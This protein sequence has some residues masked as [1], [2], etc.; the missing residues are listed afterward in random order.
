MTS[1]RH[2][3]PIR[4][5]TA[6]LPVALAVLLVLTAFLSL[7]GAAWAQEARYAFPYFGPDL[8]VQELIR[9]SFVAQSTLMGSFS[10]ASFSAFQTIAT[11]AALVGGIFIAFNRKLWSPLT[12]ASWLV[13]VV[14]IIFVPTSSR[15]LFYPIQL[16]SASLVGFNVSQPQNP[17]GSNGYFAFAPQV[18]AVDIASRAQIIVSDMFRSTG[19]RDLIG[20]S[21]AQNRLRANPILNA[22]EPWLREVTA[23]NVE[24][25]CSANL[26]DLFS[27]DSREASSESSGA[28]IQ[29]APIIPTV[30]FSQRWNQ[31]LNHYLS[32]S[33]FESMPP[34][35]VF[36]D[37]N[38]LPT[39]YDKAAYARGIQRIYREVTGQTSSTVVVNGSGPG[40]IT[41]EQALNAL[42]NNFFKPDGFSRTSSVNPGFFIIRNRE[43]SGNNSSGPASTLRD[44]YYPLNSQTNNL[45]NSNCSGVR[46]NQSLVDDVNNSRAPSGHASVFLRAH[47]EI[48]P[49]PAD[50]LASQFYISNPSLLNVNPLSTVWR[51]FV[52]ALRSPEVQQMPV[53]FRSF[54]GTTNTASNGAV[55]S[56]QISAATDTGYN[57]ATRGRELVDNALNNTLHNRTSGALA[58][59]INILKNPEAFPNSGLLNIGNIRT[60]I[61]VS[62]DVSRT[63]FDL[64]NSI[65]SNLRDLEISSAR[66]NSGARITARER[67]LVALSD[68]MQH[69]QVNTGKLAQTQTSTERS[70]EEDGR[71][72]NIVGWSGLTSV[73]G[74]IAQFMGEVLIT[75][76]AIF[77]GPIAQAFI[78]FIS[79][80]VQLSLLALIVLTPFL[81][82]AG[83]LMPG[84]AAGIFI[85]SVVAAFILQF[86]PVTLIIL[87]YLGGF[88]YDIIGATAGP[89]AWTMQNMLIIGMAGLYTSIVSLTLYLMFKLGDPAAMLGRLGA[90]DSAA[91]QAADAGMKATIAAGTLLAG[92]L[93]GAGAALAGSGKLGAL[94]KAAGQRLGG[95]AATDAGAA[96]AGAVTGSSSGTPSAMPQKPLSE[97]EG[98]VPGASPAA[99]TGNDL[100]DMLRQGGFELNGPNGAAI[101]EAAQNNPDGKSVPLNLIDQNGTSRRVLADFSGGKMQA[102][103]EKNADGTETRIPPGPVTSGSPD[104]AAD[105]GEEQPAE[106]IQPPPEDTSTSATAV[107]SG[108]LKVP[109]APAPGGAAPGSAAPAAPAAPAAAAAAAASAQAKT[110]AEVNEQI[111]QGAAMTQGQVETYQQMVSVRRG[112]L[113]QDLLT[114]KTDTDKK[115]IQKHIDELES[116]D[117][118]KA[119]MGDALS[120]LSKFDSEVLKMN[121]VRAGADI[122]P[123]MWKVMG[124]GFLG[125]FKAVGGG[126]GS[127]PVIG[128]ILKG[129]LNEYYEA[130]ERA[131]AWQAAGGY[132]KY[133]Q[134]AADAQRM[135][136]YQQGISPLAA[137]Y[138]YQQMELVGGFQ[139]MPETARFQ[140]A[141]SVARMRSDY[142]ALMSKTFGEGKFTLNDLKAGTASVNINALDLQG[143]GRVS[144]ASNIGS[145]WGEA[146]AMQGNSWKV[147]VWDDAKKEFVKQSIKPNV[148]ALARIYS[149]LGVKQAGKYFDE[150]MTN[151]YGIVEKQYERGSADWNATRNMSNDKA[152]AAKFIGED[153]ST[154]Y[155]VAGHLK[156]VQG[157][158]SFFGYRGSYESFLQLRN[159]EEG[160]KYEKIIESPQKIIDYMNDNK[161]KLKLSDAD[162]Q[163]AQIS[164]K[165]VSLSNPGALKN[166]TPQVYGAISKAAGEMIGKTSLPLSAIFEESFT[167]SRANIIEK[168]LKAPSIINSENE[169]LAVLVAKSAKTTAEAVLGAIPQ[170]ATKSIRLSDPKS[171]VS[172]GTESALEELGYFMQGVMKDSATA[173]QVIQKAFNNM[174]KANLSNAD[175]A[176]LFDV[177]QENKNGILN[178]GLRMN[179]TMQKYLEDAAKDIN[180][181]AYQNL[182]NG[183]DS[184]LKKKK[185]RSGEDVYEFKGQNYA[186]DGEKKG[187]YEAESTEVNDYANLSPAALRAKLF[188]DFQA[189]KKLNRAEKATSDNEEFKNFI[190]E[191]RKKNGFSI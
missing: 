65:N 190:E 22:G 18:V 41:V 75:V 51:K 179:S 189:Q 6:V 182:K 147:E 134:T 49:L 111:G 100:T 125:G 96:M 79:I 172:I 123:G 128:N 36:Y 85:I 46:R 43:Y 133:K 99:T 114:A 92:G 44:C 162:I 176:K 54:Q 116:F 115:A 33:Y 183:F 32:R 109:A 61:N 69:I 70:A 175:Q 3:A 110:V 60:S 187:S 90:L 91:K 106:D 149:D 120:F 98:G 95:K 143:L 15:L 107:S 124:S 62:S 80:L 56:V 52:V 141:Q 24:Y 9:G 58:P 20:Q 103:L 145:I 84:T 150:A 39:N 76:G 71:S 159:K 94:M 156:M 157:K 5:S 160:M 78:G 122:K 11:L 2:G 13:A 117:G 93:L 10:N 167:T 8:T 174:K 186:Y 131:K 144:A 132:S 137:G 153:I 185:S 154:D 89:R 161:A 146:A 64:M 31:L 139:A 168:S 118:P 40:V 151:W 136:F 108:A 47:S 82:L 155:I 14:T 12:I 166:F 57:C 83:V 73:G 191:Q 164:L 180:Q 55:E 126:A 177:V 142:E 113:M 101:M 50:R 104:P 17:L 158:Q 152:A 66:Q 129:S 171:G 4:A 23:H 68:V 181:Q 53:G 34:A 165:N 16:S 178:I 170:I 63:A 21:L 74:G 138:Q 27:G 173:N 28:P 67:H 59:L 25:G 87:N 48:S 86:V 72:V 1:R 7:S 30:S 163:N 112:Q 188:S 81:I 140:V 169:R 38:D 26:A 77:T 127:I 130:P 37:D 42:Q 135:K 35:I 97:T 119:T 29:T 105:A 88:I 102:Y 184:S 45:I 121:E 148:T 19:W